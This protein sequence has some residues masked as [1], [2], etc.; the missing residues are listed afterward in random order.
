MVETHARTRSP[1]TLNPKPHATCELPSPPCGWLL[2]SGGA[3]ALEL[4]CCRAG[5]HPPPCLSLLP[6]HDSD[7]RAGTDWPTWGQGLDPEPVS[8]FG[9]GIIS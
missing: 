8:C 2:L 7:P 6:F 1:N 5:S 3:H 4:S 9:D